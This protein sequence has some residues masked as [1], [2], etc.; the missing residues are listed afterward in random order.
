MISNK[1]FEWYKTINVFLKI[2]L[3]GLLLIF[4]I[5]WLIGSLTYPDRI[6]MFIF[7]L[8]FGCVLM[9]FFYPDVFNIIQNILKIF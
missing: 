8:I 7:G 2:V 6:V 1:F 3:F 4:G 5:L 9:Y